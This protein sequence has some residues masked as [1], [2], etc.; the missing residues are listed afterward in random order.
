MGIVGTYISYASE[1]ASFN[2]SL[3]R[4]LTAYNLA[5]SPTE[6]V[7]QGKPCPPRTEQIKI[8]KSS[9]L[10]SEEHGLVVLVKKCRI[11]PRGQSVPIFN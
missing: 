1:Q 2:K 3:M 11:R 7:L 10:V 6:V 4:G 8:L 5:Q 9:S